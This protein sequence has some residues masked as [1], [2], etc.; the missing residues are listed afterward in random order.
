MLIDMWG[1]PEESDVGGW[2]DSRSKC[3]KDN[4]R[5]GMRREKGQD[6]KSQQHRER[7]LDMSVIVKGKVKRSMMGA[8]HSRSDGRFTL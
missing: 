1:L 4:G 6:L 7:V 3:R 8:E 2:Q 5:R